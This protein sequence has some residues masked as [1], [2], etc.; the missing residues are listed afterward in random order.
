MC[1]YILREGRGREVGTITMGQTVYALK[2]FIPI[3]MHILIGSLI[4]QNL[5]NVVNS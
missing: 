2:L 4:L 1:H 3:Q 5:T